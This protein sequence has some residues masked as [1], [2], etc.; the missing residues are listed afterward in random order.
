MAIG[1]NFRQLEKTVTKKALKNSALRMTNEPT[2]REGFE[3]SVPFGT[4]D[5]KSNA[6]DHSA[7]S[8]G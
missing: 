1:V 8:P 7:T 5:F 3:P 6:F 4:F 2:E